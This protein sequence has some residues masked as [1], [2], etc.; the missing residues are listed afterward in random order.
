MLLYNLMKFL[1]KIC[2][3]LSINSLVFSKESHF[4]SFPKISLS[5]LIKYTGKIA[6][7]NFIADDNDL[8][9]N[10]AFISQSSRSS[11]Q[12]L[13]DVLLLIK[14]QG[15]EVIK[16]DDS[17]LI[18]KPKKLALKSIPKKEFD[19]YKLKYHSGEEIVAHLK[20]IKSSL[21]EN[22]S[23]QDLKITL[24]TIQWVKSSNTLF[25]S[26]NPDVSKRLKDLI[27][28]IDT[29]LKQVYVEVLVLETEVKNGQDFGVSWQNSPSADILKACKDSLSQGSTM[30]IIGDAIINGKKIFSEISSFVKF[31]ESDTNTNIVLNQKIL[32]RENKPSKI[33]EGDN[34][35]FAGSI[36]ELTGTN[37]RT[38]S[39]I[40]YKDIGVLLNLTPMI[41]D[42]GIIT[43]SIDEQITESHDYLI[44]NSTNLS[45]I[46]TSKTQMTTEAH[47][48]DNHFLVLSGMS[49][50]V[51][52]KRITGV[53]ILRSIP[54][55]GR[56][57]SSEKNVEQKKN[58]I[59]FVRPHIVNNSSA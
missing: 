59:I 9:I 49:R 40:E 47:I 3:L 22:P 27:E 44:D 30:S 42:N 26:A 51:K 12:I 7:V 24:S 57:F 2:L 19:L 34:V 21:S 23:D 52:S 41:S 8:D 31:L 39:N 54:L 58:L 35:P 14:E 15:L 1:I 18:K 20:N 13:K 48:P 29:P 37:Q 6:E 56:L 46:K 38:T 33:F 11:D 32:A 16:N 36:V 10:V 43:L 5:E 28:K 55:L 45:G 53:P 4:C 17:Y 25:F 50:K